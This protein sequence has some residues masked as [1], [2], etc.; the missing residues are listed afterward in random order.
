MSLFAIA[1]RSIKQRSLASLLT[2]F[3]MA[4]GV[5]LM[6]AVITIH[7]V[8]Q[9][10]FRVG[11]Q[12]GFNI[13]VGPKGGKLQLTLNSVYYL[14][15]PIENIPYTYYLEFK[16]QA[17]RHA[18]F[19]N[20]LSDV[21]NTLS[22]QVSDA[23]RNLMDVGSGHG[24][25]GL[26]SGAA[27]QLL[28]QQHE[29]QD[30]GSRDGRYGPYIELAIPLLLGDYYESF[31]VVGTTPDL[32]GTLKIG[33]GGDESYE[34]S[35][36]RNF[37]AFDKTN[38]YFEA[39]VGS[40]VARQANVKLGDKINPRHGAVDGHIHNEPFTVVGILAPTGTPNDRA[41]FVNMDGFYLMADHAKPVEETPEDEEAAELDED[42]EADAKPAEFDIRTPLPVEQREV[43]A[44][45][46]R[47]G[48]DDPVSQLFAV[49]LPNE[50]NEGSVAQA[51]YPI[52]EIHRFF[53]TFIG[54]V[55]ILLLV[56]TLMICVVSGVSILVSIYNSMNDRRQEIAVLRALGAG[57]NTVLWI[58]LLESMILSVAGGLIGWLLGHGL[59]TVASSLWVE[60]RTGVSIGFF[61]FAP[62]IAAWLPISLELLLVPL[63]IALAMIVGLIPAISAYRTDVAKSLGK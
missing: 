60:A 52:Q 38:G 41:V 7:G 18:D 47:V 31:R 53:G 15:Q 1:L 11:E 56:I 17:E 3:S 13:L 6:V 30:P 27:L 55:L 45:L 40:I 51:V 21:A 16:R 59:V 36:G 14:D 19:E 61:H 42:T 20:S 23:T 39:V 25:S 5:S 29:E 49:T 22:W 46:L 12:L 4:L 34:F 37:K 62:P 48:G 9:E 2:C 43:T 33:P 44:I 24:S 28:R 57:R 54:P 63:L 35:E 10:S 50:I 26:L 8:V 58:I 32:F